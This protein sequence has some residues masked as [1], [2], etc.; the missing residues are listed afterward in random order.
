M[1]LFDKKY[2]YFMWDDE[3]EGKR[4]FTSNDINKLVDYVN[5]NDNLA[6]D[7][8]NKGNSEYPFSANCTPVRFAYYDPNYDIKWAWIHKKQLQI[9]LYPNGDWTDTDYDNLIDLEEDLNQ[10]TLRIKPEEEIVQPTDN[11]SQANL[12]NYINGFPSV[13]NPCKLCY[14]GES[15]FGN[16][17]KYRHCRWFYGSYFEV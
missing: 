7:T 17:E 5:N 10:Y 9:Q 8:I 1:E 6:I 4:C 16:R 3:L 2:V 11:L 12:E 15:H 13:I 14:F